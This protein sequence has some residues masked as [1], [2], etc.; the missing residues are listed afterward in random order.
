[1]LKVIELFA[2]VGSQTQALK[3]IGVKHEVVGIAEIDKYA[4]SSYMQLHG[5]THN[6]GD[7]SKIDNLPGVD[8]WTY[9]F[10][11]QDLSVAGKGAGIKEGTR[12]GLLFEV[13]RLLEVSEKPRYLLMENVK[14]LV[15]KKNKPDFDRWC[16]KLEELGYTNYWQVLNAKDYGVPQNRE[17]VFMVSILGEHKPYIFPGKEELKIRLKDVLETE[18]EDKFFLSEEYMQRFLKSKPIS[19]TDIKIIGTTVG[20]GEGTNCRHWVHSTDGIIGALSATDYKQPKQL[21]IK[22]ATKKGYTEATPGDYINLQF[23]ESETRRGRVQ[24]EVSATLMCNDSNGVLEQDFKIRKL[25]PR[26]CWRLMGWKDEE[27]DK[28]QGISNSQLYKQAGNGIV[29]TVL[30]K[31]FKNMFK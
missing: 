15:G 9:S 11:C 25:T 3:N 24:K 10:P 17:R 29:V 31:I 8:L 5:E 20:T 1:M 14:N 2:G 12:S 30:E 16:K 23:P 26:E 28:V 13:E 19:D 7:I 22:N 27:F 4:I 6:F 18:V 21:L